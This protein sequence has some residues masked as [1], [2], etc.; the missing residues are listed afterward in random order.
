MNKIRSKIHAI[1]IDCLLVGAIFAGMYI[2]YFNQFT[3]TDV[4]QLIYEA[5]SVENPDLA[6]GGV[7]N[8]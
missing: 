7:R 4:Y 5:G 2:K 1:I 8:E 3:F 6:N